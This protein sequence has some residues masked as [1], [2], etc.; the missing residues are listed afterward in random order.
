MDFA[1][2]EEER[3]IRD[4]ARDFAAE[5]LAPDAAALDL[6]EGR[7]TH[8]ANL[9]ELAG[10]GFMALCADPACGGAGATAVAYALAIEEIAAACAST[11]TTVSVTNLAAAV[12]SARGTPA[13]KAEHVAKI[14]SGEHLAAAFCLTE[15]EAGSDPAAMRMAARRDGDAFVLDGEKLFITSAPIAGVFVTFAKTDP[16]AP[17]GKGISCLLVDVRTPGVIVG[18]PENKM[19]QRGSET[20][21]VR[22]EGARVHESA[23]IGAEHDGFRIAVG[24]LAGG[25]IGIAALSIGVAR[26]ATELARGYM[27]ERKQFGSRLADM[28]GLQWALAD[29]LV[30]IEAARLLTLDAAAKKDRGEPY[31]VA[32]SM[33][34][35]FASEMAG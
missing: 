1:L 35:L 8:L 4:A 19:G 20:A 33:A 28:Q 6:G 5:R 34:K 17:R 30:E 12:I 23:L 7:E 21:T 11:A 32:A 16:A 9:R 22:F 2:T 26:R 14:A 13:Q 27:L 10:L 25:R 15:S 31:A 24:E 18:R 3:A 29:R